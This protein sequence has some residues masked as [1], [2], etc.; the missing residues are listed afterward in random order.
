MTKQK[1]IGTL[2]DLQSAQP[3][4]ETT[5]ERVDNLEKR[6]AQLESILNDVMQQLDQPYKNQQT[7]NEKPHSNGKPKQM[8]QTKPKQAKPKLAKPNP[9]KAKKAPTPPTPAT[10]VQTQADNIA[11][12]TFLSHDPDRLYHGTKLRAAIQELCSLSN[13][14]VASA[15]MYFRQTGHL[16]VVKD[17]Q[18]DG[19][20]LN[21]AYKFIP[22]PE[23]K[24]PDEKLAKQKK[25]AAKKLAAKQAKQAQHA[26]REKAQKAAATKLVATAFQELQVILE[27]GD[28]IT[29]TELQAKG[30]SLN[31]QKKIREL[32]D[33][34]ESGI[35]CKELPDETF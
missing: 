30:I 27:N 34:K 12:T 10:E 8:K 9:K 20:Q 19:K 15:I 31:R 24:T 21:G 26:E 18:V 35:Q 22:H 3:V 6:V 28:H 29:S 14:Q 16:V 2:A 4:P 23:P 7:G 13:Q 32:D 25:D 5:D 11:I 33:Y 1:A 17:V